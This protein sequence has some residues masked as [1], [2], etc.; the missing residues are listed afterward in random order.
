MSDN[1]ADPPHIP[2]VVNNPPYVPPET[3]S[4]PG[5]VG[6][7]PEADPKDPPPEDTP[8]KRKWR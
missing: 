6:T 4:T 5:T 3:P 2:G 7:P 8:A 1:P